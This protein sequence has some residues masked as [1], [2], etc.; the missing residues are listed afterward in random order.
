MWQNLRISHEHK[1]W[2]LVK[3]SGKGHIGAGGGS[4]SSWRHLAWLVI[5]IWVTHN[6]LFMAASYSRVQTGQGPHNITGSLHL[7][8]LTPLKIQTLLCA[9][10][11][12]KLEERENKSLEMKETTK[13]LTSCMIVE[14]TYKFL[15][16]SFQRRPFRSIS[17]EPG[18]ISEKDTISPVGGKSIMYEKRGGVSKERGLWTV[19]GNQDW[20]V[21]SGR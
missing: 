19:A 17:A 11:G 13:A 15:S 5:N 16:V 6:Y 9:L 1:H 4:A 20:Y 12:Q 8:Y 3:T 10:Y 18:T 7:Q 14:I 2:L 21:L